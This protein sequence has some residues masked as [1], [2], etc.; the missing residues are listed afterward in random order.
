MEAALRQLEKLDV[1]ASKLPAPTHL[2]GQ[3]ADL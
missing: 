2:Q 1:L 3:P